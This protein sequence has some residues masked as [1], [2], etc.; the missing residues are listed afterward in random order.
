MGLALADFEFET[1]RPHIG[2]EATCAGFVYPIVR[3][4]D[5]NKSEL[6]FTTDMMGSNPIS[7][8]EIDL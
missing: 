8:I 4:K 1:G 5:G 2:I 3:T 7:R 6:T